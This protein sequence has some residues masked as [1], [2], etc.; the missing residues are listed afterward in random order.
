MVCTYAQTFCA[1]YNIL[2][3]TKEM[4]FYKYIDVVFK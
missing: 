4:R 3:V 2:R 1:I